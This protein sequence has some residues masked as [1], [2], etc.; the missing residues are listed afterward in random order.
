MCVYVSKEEIPLYKLTCVSLKQHF[1]LVSRC[2]VSTWALGEEEQFSASGPLQKRA[3]LVFLSSELAS[4]D[5][6]T[7]HLSFV[8][9]WTLSKALGPA[10][11]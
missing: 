9:L 5:W 11:E 3:L 8:P 7:S 10:G 2:S 1:S 4:F 6:S